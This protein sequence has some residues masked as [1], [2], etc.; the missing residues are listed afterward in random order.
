MTFPE[1][2]RSPRDPAAAPTAPDAAAL[3][4]PDAVAP[5]VPAAAPTAPDSASDIAGGHGI[6]TGQWHHVSGKYATVEIV[7]YVISIVIV[8]AIAA[9]IAVLTGTLWS[10]I[11]GG[12]LLLIFL[13]NMVLI[14]RRVRSIR[15]QLRSDDLLFRRGIMWQRQVAVPY[16][17][18]QLIDIERGPIARMVGLSELKFVTAAATTNLTIPGMPIE[19]AEA[20]RDALVAV[21]ETRR[22]GL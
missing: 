10:W 16:G 20:L 11:G 17:R 22:T 15:Y 3:T 14:P 2:A 9:V 7:G 21:A 8:S 18:M 4:A 1:P 13:I 19:Q 12:I 6:A 5:P